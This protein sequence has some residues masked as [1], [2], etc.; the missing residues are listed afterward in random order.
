MFMG[1]RCT[2]ALL[3]PD[4]DYCRSLKLVLDNAPGVRCVAVYDD[5]TRAL[6]ELPETPPDVLLVDLG[7][8]NGHVREFIH[9]LKKQ[10]PQIALLAINSDT[11]EGSLVSAF[12]AGVAGYL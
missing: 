12:R 11:D 8:A 6:L 4:P 2:V 9:H 10:L 5:L 7:L 3:V 1:S